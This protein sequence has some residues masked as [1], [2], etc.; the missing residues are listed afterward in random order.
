MYELDPLQFLRRQW[1]LWRGA[2]GSLASSPRAAAPPTGASGRGTATPATSSTRSTPSLR[3]V[4]KFAHYLKC[5]T[6]YLWFI[7]FYDMSI[8]IQHFRGQDRGSR[9][10][11][12]HIGNIPAKK[13]YVRL[14]MG[15]VKT[16]YSR[17]RTQNSIHVVTVIGTHLAWYRTND[18]EIRLFWFSVSCTVSS[19]QPSDAKSNSCLTFTDISGVPAGSSPPQ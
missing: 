2:R 19:S 16:K 5:I 1:R 7:S 6:S 4:R 12:W 8:K 9:C 10:I 13:S 15:T 17:E 11:N 14:H 3:C 18:Y